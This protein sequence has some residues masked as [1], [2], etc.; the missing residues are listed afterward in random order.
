MDTSEDISQILQ[1]FAELCHISLPTSKI[2]N[3]GGEDFLAIYV[4]RSNDIYTD[5]LASVRRDLPETNRFRERV[6]L[7]EK[8]PKQW[9]GSH[10]T[11]LLQGLLSESLTIG[12]ES[13]HSDFHAKMIPFLGG[14]ERRIVNE[15]NHVVFGRR[16]AGKSSLLLH[17]CIAAQREHVPFAWIAMQNYQGRDDFQVIPQVL[18][19]LADAI[20]EF[21]SVAPEAGKLREI[22]NGLEGRGLDLTYSNVNLVL[23][24]FKRHLL[25]FVRRHQR[26]YIFL[27]DLHLVHPKIQ[28]YLLSALYSISR[29]NDI[30]LKTTSIEYLTRLYDPEAQ[31]GL[32]PPGDAQVIR[33]DYNLMNP[34]AAFNHIKSI[35]DSYVKYVGIPSISSLT[36]ILPLERLTWT[37]A[38]V[39]RDALYIFNNAI[40][41]ALAAKRSAVTVT[42]INMASAE[43]LTEKERYISDDVRD[44]SAK[45]RD[46]IEDIREFCVK[47][48]KCNAFLV[49]IKFRDPTYEVIHR[50]SDLRFIHVLHSGITPETAGEKY[51]VFLLDYAF[52]VGFRKTPSVREV[53]SKPITPAVK[54]LRKL[55]RY[56]YEERMLK[57]DGDTG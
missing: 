40:S 20:S 41:K 23:P 18:Y 22:V 11:Q 56:N 53:V 2:V 46:V 55:R 37:C 57:R 5:C 4:G 50:I 13:L 6:F 47:E 1:R 8:Q 32:Q 24:V 30:Y 42:D 25:P 28:P 9:L 38:G 51:E 26:L 29:G 27:D 31:V 39:P 43:S 16:G 19:E 3:K 35:L 48:A 21:E 49:H 33:L 52:Y 34:E 12:R 10:E 45:V 17:A 44:N 54:E 7:R 36:G 14:E 15:A